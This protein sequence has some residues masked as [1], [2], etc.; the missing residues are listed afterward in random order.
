VLVAATAWLFRVSP[1]LG[2]HMVGGALY[3]LGPV[4]LMFLAFALSNNLTL[5][6]VSGLVYSLLSPSIFLI[7]S[8]R[9][10]IGSLWKA[11]RL[12]TLVAYGDAPHVSSIT[13]LL[14]AILALHLAIERRGP[15]RVLAAAVMFAAVVLT[16]WLGA[17]SSAIACVSYLLA[18]EDSPR[19]SKW[20]PAFAYAPA[21]GLTA[22]A[23]AAPWIP[24]STILAVERNAQFTVGQYPMGIRQLEYAGL[25]LLA[26][27]VL[28][29]ILTKLR[30][31]LCVRFSS[32]FLLVMAALALPAEWFHVYLMPQPDRYQLEME[33]GVCLVLVFVPGRY[34]MNAA[35]KR[36]VAMVVLVAA[37]VVFGA[38]QAQNYRRYFRGVAH[39]IDIYQTVE[40]Q[41]G[42]WLQENLPN[43]RIFTQGS[44]RFWLNA[45]SDNPQVG[46][47]FDQGIVNTEIPVIQFGIPWTLGDGAN[48]AMWL[49]LF[50]AGALV[51]SGPMSRDSYPQAWRDPDKFRGVLPELWR[52]GGDAIY[53]VP[54]RSD[55]LAHVILPADVVSRPPINV[56]DVEQAQRLDAAL[57]NPALPVANFVWKSQA[58][59]E[60]SAALQ[61]LHVVLVQVTYHRGWRALVN[62]SPRPVRRDGLGFMLIEPQ[63]SGP[64]RIRLQYDG[65]TEMRIAHWASAITAILLLLACAW[66][67]RARRLSST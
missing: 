4:A 67:F 60:I 55:S 66:Q 24:P 9:A 17:F 56:F 8:V 3:C 27:G 48:A 52:S 15:A 7:P 33:I 6:F 31:S 51:V 42:R 20:A 36:R 2:H 5:S 35:Q 26:G 23:L 54:Q 39:R 46:G 37:L 18:R 64:C 65:G 43:R 22:Y 61:P 30:A 58:E 53:G 28:R 40:Y 32:Y 19:D 25:L 47:G 21:I 1:A 41:S 10:D 57:E 45:F 49:R 14:V 38:V 59:A 62:G 12:E 50:G 63:C 34:L 13:L 44:I 11:R 29:W 16:N